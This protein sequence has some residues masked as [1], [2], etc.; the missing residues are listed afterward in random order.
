VKPWKGASMQ[1]KTEQQKAKLIKKL[2]GEA[3]KRW[4]GNQRAVAENF[5]RQ[6]FE[7]VP[8]EV[9]VG[10]DPADLFGSVRAHWT[11]G[12]SRPPG[13][14][15]VRVYNPSPARMGWHSQHTVVETITDDMPF[16]V[17]SVVAELHRQELSVHTVIHPI[18]R[19][20]RGKS[21]NL[22]EVLGPGAPANA[23]AAESFM[24]IEVTRQST[25]R[26]KEIQAGLEAVLGDIRAV[27]ED[28]RDMR[29]KMAEVVV[30]LENRPATKLAAEDVNE[31]RDFLCWA[32]ANNFTF[33][34]FR[35]YLYKESGGKAIV[36]INPK[37]GL[38]ILRDPNVTVFREL[39]ALV[40][41]PGL[42]MVTKT[43]QRST[44]HR[45]VHMDAIGI[46]CLDSKGKA[47]GQHLFVGL[48]TSSAYHSSPREIPFLR[49]KVLKIF[50]RA[51]MPP[52]S[53]DG[54]ALLNVLETFP[55][56][57]LFQATEEHMFLTCL[58]IMNLHE[59]P[60]VALFIRR[61]EYERFVS[62]LVYIP[63]DL[64]STDLRGRLHDILEEAFAGKVTAH[65][66]QLGE[67]LLARLHT[68]IRTTPGR[69][70]DYD[71]D[72]IEARLA[73][74][75][76]TWSDHLQ[77]ALVDAHG[78]EKGAALHLRYRRAFR[79][80]YRER[81]DAETALADIAKVEQTLDT[82]ELGMSLRGP[83]AAAANI[84]WF[85]VYHPEQPIPLSD[86][87]PMLE[88]MGLKVITEIPY[89]IHPEN[90]DVRLVMIHDFK[91][92]TRNAAGVDLDSIRDNFK[93]AF[94]RV[95]RGEVESDGFNALVL[96]AGL[97][98][99]Q[100]VVLRAYCK[101]LRQAGC[102]FSQ[103]YME[104]TLANNPLMTRLFVELFQATFDPAVG[105]D[106]G[107]RA[108]KIG[109]KLLK[110]LEAVASADEDRIL[111][112]YLNLI[113]CTLRTNFFQQE[114]AG[115]PKPYLSFKLDSRQVDELPLPRPFREI[116]V[117]CPRVEGIHLRFGKVARGGL[118]W[119]DRREDFRTEILG[120]VKA[121]QVK[122]AVIV[123]VGSKG[124]FV[125][126][127]PPDG[128]DREALIDEGIECYRTFIRGLLDITDNRKGN[129]VAA[130]ENVVRLDDDDPYLVVAADKGTA[131]FSDIANTISKAYG[132]WLGDA[133]ASGGG[134]GYDHKKMAI[135][136][137]GAWES[138]KRHFRELGLDIQEQNFTVLGVGDMSGDVFGNGMLLS[139]R[140]K[141]I[142]A[143]NHRH[144]FVD[145]DPHPA[146]GIGERKRLF[147]LPRSSWNDYDGKLISKGGGVFDRHAKSLTLSPE[148]KKRF[149]ITK[150]R[151]TP[152]ELIRALLAAQV[153][154]LWFA[155]IGTYVKSSGESAAEVGDRANDAVRVDVP[156]LRCRVIGE[157]AN[158]GVT[159]RARIEFALG[160]GRVYTDFIDNSAGVDC[161][162]HEV[163]I[164]LLL[165]QLAA[166]G[167]MTR[168]QRNALL[169]RMTG[170]VAELVLRDNY[171]QSQAI[172]LIDA[173]RLRVFDDQ[174]RLMRL[175]EKKGRLNREVE[176]LPDDETL[177]ERAAAKQGLA[178]PEISVLMCYSKIWLYDELVQS[179]LPDD[180]YLAADL[181]GYFPAPLRR[182]YKKAIGG[183]RLRREIIA[184]RVTNSMINRVGGT[185]VHHFSERSGLPSSTIARAYIITREVFAI[186]GLWQA[187]EDLD[188]V[189]P[190]SIQ[191]AMFLAINRLIDWGTLWFLRHGKRPLDIG[192]CACE[193]TKGIEALV[194]GLDGVLPSRYRDDVG[195]RAQPFTKN[196]VPEDLALRVAGLVNLYAAC[197]IVCLAGGRK[198][199]V[200]AVAQL[201]FAVGTRFMMG[202]LRAASERMDS[203]TYWQ[204]LAVAALVEE[205]YDHQ[206]ALTAQILDSADGA[207]AVDKAIAIWEDKNRAAVERTDQLLAELGASEI[208]DLSMIA[209]ASRQLRAMAES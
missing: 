10:G 172:N 155:G 98:W 53:H 63:R 154:L 197:D 37:K 59:R 124:G 131:A 77:Q 199:A 156:A 85:K 179:D 126:K 80:G 83:A 18:V 202:H 191:T 19:L 173:N 114:D 138:V 11:F 120:L 150:N 73:D 60:R 130:P 28:W 56:D 161:S 146:T 68:I 158:L 192:A 64:F 34:G 204:K 128:G 134:A 171:L 24:H 88:H 55:R 206:L 180:P 105:K 148:I 142:G 31:V 22:R 72:E 47:I 151:V 157:G 2:V 86:V 96:G 50:E 46:K 166:A 117:Y 87:L 29:E 95:W 97:T 189:V 136:A 61:D 103:A 118:R 182:K 187:I 90:R 163:N 44:I 125:V 200:I 40:K 91:L 13:K 12:A 5:I 76:R 139:P 145:P 48:F 4:P 8:A 21:G 174:V 186:R 108:K 176:F 20:R 9:I 82:G 203:Q 94:A 35:E 111:R 143:F 140:I 15:K 160:G 162:D 84:F 194:A 67:T 70:P 1:H 127:R 38:G 89:A 78:E 41:Q 65:Y 184:T 121:Q 42:L 167:E 175:L 185:F 92:E 159:Q 32:H 26:L 122:N 45:P 149:N 137:R 119:S 109:K 113:E 30:E 33:L 190:A 54:K 181:I 193:F 69:I 135:T 183:H 107:N 99:R 66:S 81:F 198:V 147:G 57:E 62:C 133:F 52:T 201:Y 141:L 188:N 106:A 195:E 112:R 104:Q 7:H 14:A 51:G 177:G 208:N 132:F 43:N 74:A 58:G 71:A 17:D 100:V 209:V 168:K 79:S 144:I 129:K 170:E 102:A 25:N 110:G 169:V 207:V 178:A 93:D 116:F 123:P 23:A 49:R 153:D 205:I 36:R 27:I 115:G 16:L 196:G 165:D 3:K 6:Y 75:A 152:N 164:K 101:Y 39:S